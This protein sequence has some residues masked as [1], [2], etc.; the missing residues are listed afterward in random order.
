MSQPSVIVAERVRLRLRAEGTDP[1]L[2]PDAALRIAQVE[3]RRHNDHALSRGERLIDDEARCIRDVL[4]A[5]SGFGPLQPLLDDPEVEEIR[6]LHRGYRLTRAGV[7][8]GNGTRHAR[9]LAGG[10]LRKA[11]YLVRGGFQAC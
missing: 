3:V 9:L 2:D 8:R 1:S 7:S 6:P 4:A 11:S 5:V 10:A